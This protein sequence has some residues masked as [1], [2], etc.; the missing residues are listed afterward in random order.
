METFDKLGEWILIGIICVLFFGVLVLMALFYALKWSWKNRKGYFK[1]LARVYKQQ[2]TC[3]HT[4]YTTVYQSKRYADIRRDMCAHCS[5][6][7]SPHVPGGVGRMMSHMGS[8]KLP[9]PSHFDLLGM[10]RPK[11][12]EKTVW[13]D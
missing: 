13:G 10:D 11:Y 7:Y 1:N 6:E 4:E 9:D 3:K 12:T 2:V 5:L 8:G